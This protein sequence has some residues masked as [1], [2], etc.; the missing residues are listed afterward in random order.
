MGGDRQRR[1]PVIG[2]HRPGRGDEA[3]RGLPAA[4]QVTR[5]PHPTSL[6]AAVVTHP[7]RR[8]GVRRFGGRYEQSYALARPHAG[9]VSPTGNHRRR[10][11]VRQQP[12][13]AAPFSVLPVGR[14]SARP[15][16]CRCVGTALWR[17]YD[18]TRR[19]GTRRCGCPRTLR[20]TWPGVRW[21]GR[22]RRAART[23]G[24]ADDEHQQAGNRTRSRRPAHHISGTSDPDRLLNPRYREPAVRHSRARQV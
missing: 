2:G 15:G 13:V 5:G 23:A 20:L 12:S 7:V 19:R 11:G 17:R 9:V 10:G 1:R 18:V 14:C 4:R 3:W 24:P 22:C 6:S 16:D 8:H 21:H